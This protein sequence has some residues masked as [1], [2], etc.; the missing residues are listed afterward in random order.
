MGP[1]KGGDLEAETRGAQVTKRKEN[2]MKFQGR[3]TEIKEPKKR[4]GREDVL[5]CH[6]GELLEPYGGVGILHSSSQNTKC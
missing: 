6:F 3:N 4:E 2:I 1:T 5:F